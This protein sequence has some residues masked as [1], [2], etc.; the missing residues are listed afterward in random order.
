MKMKRFRVVSASLVVFLSSVAFA[1][2][3]QPDKPK[4]D[5][6]KPVDVQPDKPKKDTSKAVDAFKQSQ[7]EVKKCVADSHGTAIIVFA[8]GLN[9]SSSGAVVSGV[10][11]IWK[12]NEDC[13]VKEQPRLFYV[14][15]LI[16]GAA[17]RMTKTVKA[18]VEKDRKTPVILI[19]HSMGGA[20]LEDLTKAMWKEEL[21]ADLLIAI[22]AVAARTALKP[23]S[24]GIS[25]DLAEAVTNTLG[26]KP[27]IE[28]S[29]SPYSIVHIL[30]DCKGDSPDG[31]NLQK[32]DVPGA[33]KYQIKDTNHTTVDAAPETLA[34]VKHLCSLVP[35]VGINSIPKATPADYKPV[36]PPTDLSK[37]PEAVK[38]QL[39]DRV[40]VVQ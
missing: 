40:T 34:L 6:S 4:K 11:D 9:L 5:T 28:L 23:D 10:P 33:I 14:N 22:D 3:A 21:R 29:G 19:G 35:K 17:A 32:V 27:K 24:S 18:L 12:V 30:A 39:G 7:V 26:L 25:K 15:P 31:D 8:C 38:K 2:D 16:P 20:A 36:F 13:S 1:V 37:L